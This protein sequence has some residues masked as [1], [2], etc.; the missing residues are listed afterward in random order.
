[1]F[2]G[3]KQTEINWSAA[4]PR[5]AAHFLVCFFAS[6]CFPEQTRHWRPIPSWNLSNLTSSE[7]SS[8]LT[9]CHCFISAVRKNWFTEM[10][11]LC[12]YWLTSSRAACPCVSEKLRKFV[13]RIWLRIGDVLSQA[14]LPSSLPSCGGGRHLPWR[15][16][17]RGFWGEVSG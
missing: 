17:K 10:P 9:L 8:S 14:R 13:S 15:K 4:R 3:E 5:S 6:L 2:V 16:G 11:F 7:T 12:G 1:M